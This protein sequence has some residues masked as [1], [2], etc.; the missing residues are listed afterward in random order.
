MLFSNDSDGSPIDNVVLNGSRPADQLFTQLCSAGLPN[1]YG[2]AAER[3]RL[4]AAKTPEQRAA[5]R[6][7]LH[8]LLLL[9]LQNA[10][11]E[12]AAREL[13]NAVRDSRPTT[14]DCE[15]TGRG[16]FSCLTQ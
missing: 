4:E 3:D 8:E 11:R 6:R 1:A 12:R 9:Q 2:M 13:G 7:M 14:T 16:K 5:E 15:S 10:S